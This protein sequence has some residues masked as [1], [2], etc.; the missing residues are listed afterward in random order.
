[1]IQRINTNGPVKII[2]GIIVPIPV[3]HI[4]RTINIKRNGPELFCEFMAELQIGTID[5]KTRIIA[6]GIANG[7]IDRRPVVI[8]RAGCGGSIRVIGLKYNIRTKNQG[9]TT[10]ESLFEVKI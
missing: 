2:N 9:V 1:M 5:G 8:H 6:G 10:V 4:G 7:C 3:I